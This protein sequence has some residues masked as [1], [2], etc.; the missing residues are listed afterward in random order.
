[1]A[2]GASEPVILSDLY[3]D[4]AAERIVT[5]ALPYAIEHGTWIGIAPLRSSRGRPVECEQQWI[6]QRN[7]GQIV[8]ALVLIARPGLAPLEQDSDPARTELRNRRELLSFLSKG[9]AHDL[10]RAIAPL[11][12]RLT[13][14]ALALVER[15][16]V[17]GQAQPSVYTVVDL[18]EIAE[19]VS[20]WLRVARPGPRHRR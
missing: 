1:M 11:E 15:L 18:R 12:N 3:S 14:D 17:F 4:R 13:E 9:L 8:S 10:K 19:E 16:A 20:R 6:G 7:L 5:E 2:N